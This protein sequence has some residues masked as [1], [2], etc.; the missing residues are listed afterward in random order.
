[1]S[2]D[3]S[4]DD[5]G[6]CRKHVRVKVP[7]ADI[8][9]FR[10]EALD[11]VKETAAVPG[12][13]PGRVP[14]KLIEKRYK[15]E[16][17]DQVRQKV[18]LG[19][20]EQLADDKSLDPI[21][22]PDF[23]IETLILPDEGD[24]EYEFDVEVRPEFELPNY[25]GVT[26]QR[27]TREIT[28]DDVDKYIERYLMQYRR[29]EPSSEPVQAGDYIKADIEC[30]SAGQLL[31]RFSN[32]HLQVRSKL[33]FLDG[34]LENV[35]T[36]LA[37][38]VP[39][40]VKEAE[41]VISQESPSIAQR[42]ETVQVR[43]TVHTVDKAVLPELTPE[44]FESIG[45]DDLEEMRVN[46]RGTL[47]R[48]LQYE[49]RQSARKQV[50]EKITESATWELPEELVSKQVENAMRREILELQQ[51]GYTTQEIANRE[52]DLRRNSLTTTRQGLK[53]HFVLDK[54]ATKESI[55]CEEHDIESEIYMM[56]LQRGEN[57]RRVRARLQ[58]SGL[59]ENLE[60]QIR[61]RKAVD[62][63]LKSAVY[64][65]VPV[66]SPVQDDVFSIARYIC[67]ATPTVE[68]DDDDDGAEADAGE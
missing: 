57:P 63:V 66:P 60:A 29:I 7:Q 44:F 31:Q 33:R 37:G 17:T 13:R 65:D 28:D 45:V 47:Q 59:I 68:P 25:V 32:V 26:L 8:D 11:E 34:E 20:L 1:M 43:I 14:V 50:L 61:E 54:I 4:I 16:I 41:I 55:E 53:E 24:F 22:Q 5:I 2:L 21:N 36:L 64:E 67:I 27:P 10:Q 23:D 62:F 48:Q 30:L 35:D 46:A 51:A 19:S 15:K 40:T 6:P 18:L 39:G 49:Q 9:H 12:F 56:S 38:A 3:V 42:G 52:A 58:K